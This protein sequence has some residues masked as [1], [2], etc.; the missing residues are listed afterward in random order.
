MRRWLVALAAAAAPAVSA[1]EPLWYLQ[2]DNDVPFRT[3]RWYTSG[4]RVARVADGIEWG[5]LQE[6]YTP[7]AKRWHPGIADRAP[8]GRLLLSIAK[9]DVTPAAF[10]TL[11]LMAGVRGP[12]ARGRESADAI[13]RVIPAPFVDWSRG[14]PDEFDATVVASRTQQAWGPIRLHFGAQ[15]GTQVAFAHAGLEARWGGAPGS[16]SRLLRFAATPERARAAGW[17]AYAGVSLRGVGRN[18]LLSANY[19]A[20]GP[21]LARE[22]AVTRLATGVAWSGTWGAITFDL[23]QDS[24][25]FAQQRAPHRFGSLAAHVDF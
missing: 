12:S 15:L 9:H 3:D 13:H 18:E 24:R 23:A 7:E 5:V 20:G 4:V 25:E 10:Q 21:G 14:L 19:D 1:A 6:I 17:S 11:E 8:V 22:S 16:A 2:L